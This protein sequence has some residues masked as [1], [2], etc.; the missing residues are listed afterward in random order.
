MA[1][2]VR[3]LQGTGVVGAPVSVD[4]LIVSHFAGTAAGC[5]PADA[6]DWEPFRS[7]IALIINSFPFVNVVWKALDVIAVR[8]SRQ[9]WDVL[10]AT[11]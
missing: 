7:T 4:L 9:L 1:R 3:Q 8:G 11:T 6:P 10:P 5:N 2:K